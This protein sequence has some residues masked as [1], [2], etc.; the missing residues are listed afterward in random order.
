LTQILEAAVTGLEPQKPYV[1][2][3]SSKPDATGP[4]EYLAGFM[5]NPA[6][7][8]VVNAVGPIR[9]LVED[10]DD[11]SRRYLVIISGTPAAPGERVQ[12]QLPSSSQRGANR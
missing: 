12:V 11:S 7:G 3:L 6:G 5:T 1:L 9:Q 4:A 10:K 2:A 8:A